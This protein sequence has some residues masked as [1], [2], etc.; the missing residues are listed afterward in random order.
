[1]SP[2]PGISTLITSAPIQASNW[3]PVGP[4][5]TWLRS[6]T[7]T[8]SRALLIVPHLNSSFPRKREPR[9]HRSVAP[10]WAP[11]FAG[12]TVLG[13]PGARHF[14]AGRVEKIAVLLDMRGE[15]QGVLACQPLGV[16][17]VAAFERIDDPEMVGN[18]ARRA[19]FLM[20][21]DLADRTHVDEQ[22]FRHLGEQRAA[23][24]F[25]NRLMEGDV[26]IGIFSEPLTVVSGAEFGHQP[27]QIGN[28][29]VGSALGGEPR[30]HAFERRHDSDHLDD[31]ALCL[32]H[33]EDAPARAGADKAFLLQE[34][35]RLAYRR[36]AHPEP[37]RE[38]PLV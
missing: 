1:M 20:D 27:A 13:T 12:V 18:R 3:V 4:A 30:R 33:D 9:G 19:V 22:V 2:R 32:A 24:H 26:R 17:G 34:G 10:P 8:P 29:R 6:R 37:F 14:V 15:P 36:A 23:A 11:A 35:H 21:R 28:L 31:L 16:L 7:R 38:P 5:W 25:D